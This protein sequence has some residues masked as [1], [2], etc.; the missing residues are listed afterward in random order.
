MRMR[1]TTSSRRPF[2]A[3]ALLLVV[4]MLATGCGGDGSDGDEGPAG[5]PGPTPEPP[6][7]A[8][9]PLPGLDLEIVDVEGG[10][11]SNGNFESGDSFTFLF[12]VKNDQGEDVDL[13]LIASASAYV[14]GPTF[15]YQRVLA[16]ESDVVANAV[17][18]GGG[19]WSYTFAAPIPENY[20][21]PYNDSPTFGLEDGE[22]SGTELLDGTYTV[23]LQMYREHA[24]GG[25]T[26]RDAG[27]AVFDFLFGG[28]VI[29]APRDVV[30]DANCDACHTEVR[31][32]GGGRIGVRLCVLCHTS[33]AEDR[34]VLAVEGGTPGVSIDLRI[35]V[36]KIHAGKHLP[37]VVGAAAAAN[38]SVDYTVAPQPLVYVG[39]NNSVSDFSHV[40]F[41]VWPSLNIPTLRD[42]GYAGLSTVD[43]DGAGPLLSPQA[44]A[45]SVLLGPVDCAKCHGDPDG[46]GG[47][48]AP[49]QGELWKVQPSRNVCQ[50]CHDDIDWSL[51]YSSNGATMQPDFDNSTC[52]VCH[53]SEGSGLSIVD[54]H[55][56]PIQNPDYNPG[57]NVDLQSLVEAPGYSNGDGTVDAGERIRITFTLKDDQ[58][59][60]VAPGTLADTSIVISGPTWN[61]NL[62]L[63]GGL[64][65]SAL[66]GGPVHTLNVPEAIRF[67]PLGTGTANPDQFMTN[68]APVWDLP[69]APTTVWRV[70]DPAPGPTV[71]ST[72]SATPTE[73]FQNFVE[74]VSVAGFVQN[75]YVRV[76]AFEYVQVRNVL[77]TRVYFT[78]PLSTT[79]PAA[80]NVQEVAFT[81]QTVN[82]HY[83]LTPFTGTI[84]EIGASWPSGDLVISYTSDFVMP[85]V[86]PAPFNDSPD[87]GENYGE[88][89]GRALVAGTYTF[90]LWGDVSRVV[91]LYGETNSYRGTAIGGAAD[92]LVG[93]ATTIDPYDVISD[94]A[95]CYACHNDLWFHGGGRRGFTT[96][97]VC[98]GDAGGEDR[99]PYVAF[100]APETQYVTI[101][102]REMLH[103]I[104]FGRDLPDADTY[105][106]VGFGGGSAS[107]GNN[108][109]EH[110]YVEIGFP[111]MPGG[112]RQ[113]VKCHGN[114]TWHE[115]DDRTY[116]Q[117]GSTPARVWRVVCGSCHDEPGQH[118]HM[119]INT[120][121]GVESCVFCHGPGANL[122]VAKVHPPRDR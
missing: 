2:G 14:S 113:C 120:P 25:D 66:S 5:P 31:A 29:I 69:D 7:G 30:G 15:N 100:N 9:D 70:S 68:R 81:E 65:T 110:T 36:H 75:D 59:V 28:A 22:L 79:Y 37:S 121:M 3:A 114:D 61:Y 49:A 104:H 39:F 84:D 47:A 57:L 12:T 80:T 63:D 99:A 60:D 8:Y 109:S 54:A 38:G 13:S 91:N 26:L 83:T 102:F 46:P 90:N 122:D 17:Y 119:D 10:S 107:T 32:H 72:T 62:V 27:S 105:T 74:V 117:P 103:K 78:A 97:I 34:N 101:A 82:V 85:A 67:E 23:G 55:L 41:P 53:T 21:P 42:T 51:P 50:S 48:P 88:W 1:W 24:D 86:Y 116:P 73:I 16:S 71:G 56:H 115:P 77:G 35:M 112:V 93:D 96:C 89:K 111:A 45:A 95:N 4:A 44:R 20:L 64:P 52:A 106:V 76:G 18:R 108:F 33:G 40:A 19:V 11:G 98:H 87:L 92:F 43:P 118:A 6:L 58:G 94:A